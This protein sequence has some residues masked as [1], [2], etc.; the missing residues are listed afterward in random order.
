MTRRV[1]ALCY[2]W[3]DTQTLVHRQI[4]A[5]YPWVLTQAARENLK[6]NKQD[7]KRGKKRPTKTTHNN[8]KHG[9]ERRRGWGTWLERQSADVLIESCDW[10]K[11]PAC[12]TVH[13][14]GETDGVFWGGKAAPKVSRRCSLVLLW[15]SRKRWED[16]G[17]KTRRKRRRRQP[18]WVKHGESQE[19]EQKKM[20]I[21]AC[22]KK[23]HID[24]RTLAMA[25]ERT[26]RARDVQRICE[27]SEPRV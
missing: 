12:V 15:T 7:M 1:L 25:S 10:S 9:R 14:P 16:G 5:D 20:K 24:S 23:P 27:A 4:T 19:V 6:L 17:G 26:T 11:F 2:W 8:L 21:A 22:A 13:D 18:F 3:A